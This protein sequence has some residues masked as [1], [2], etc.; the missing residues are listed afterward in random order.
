MGDRLKIGQVI[1]VKK[2]LEKEGIDR[3]EL[4]QIEG[5]CKN[6]VMCRH[7]QGGYRETFHP[8][9]LYENRIINWGQALNYIKGNQHL[10]CGG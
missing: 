3:K 1:S 6:L 10:V 9:E 4:Y 7:I 8:H 2:H 5:F